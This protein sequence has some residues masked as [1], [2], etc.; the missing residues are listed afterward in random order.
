MDF[1]SSEEEED[2]DGSFEVRPLPWRSEFFDSVMKELDAKTRSLQPKKS[3]R[4]TVLRKVG[5]HSKR[6]PPENIDREV[7]GWT[8]RPEIQK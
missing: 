7:N 5:D 2:E 6:P 1:M 3:K 4:Q 8:I